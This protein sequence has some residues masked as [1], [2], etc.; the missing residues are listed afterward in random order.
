[1][2]TSKIV[3]VSKITLYSLIHLILYLACINSYL[4]FKSNIFST[5]HPNVSFYNCRLFYWRPALFFSGIISAN[6][7]SNWLSLAHKN[8]TN[9]HWKI[10]CQRDQE[11][12]NYY[13]WFLHF[14]FHH[15]HSYQLKGKEWCSVILYWTGIYHCFGNWF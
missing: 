15:P 2:W 5:V 9:R 10:V 11:E 1:M 3:L 12:E 4:Q 6:L 14:P 7:S 13:Q 8:H